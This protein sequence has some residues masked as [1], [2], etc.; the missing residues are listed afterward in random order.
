MP[1]SI[2]SL[3]DMKTQ[4]NNSNTITSKTYHV[5][6]KKYYQYLPVSKK[7]IVST[8]VISYIILYCKYVFLIISQ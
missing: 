6:S 3:C 2:F 4:K 7:K 8:N 1:K 5:W